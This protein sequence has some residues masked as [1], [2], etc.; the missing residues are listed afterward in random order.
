MAH[1]CFILEVIIGY[2]L[3][4]FIYDFLKRKIDSIKGAPKKNDGE[5]KEGRGG[6]GAD[7]GGV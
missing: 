4:S 3:G 5:G 2:I 1:L 7:G 6:G